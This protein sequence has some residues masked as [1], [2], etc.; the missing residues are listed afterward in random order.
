MGV[1]AASWRHAVERDAAWSLGAADGLRVLRAGV[2]EG[3]LAGGCLVDLGGGAGDAVCD[4]AGDADAPRVLFLED[5]GTKPYQWD[6]M[7]LHLRYAG[8]LEHVSGIV[9]GDMRQCVAPE[10]ERAAGGGDSACAAGFCGADCDWAAVGACG[11][12]ER[13]GAAGSAGAAGFE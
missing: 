1:D 10:E 3:T 9:F 4:A 7:L 11:C 8:M 5:I 6:R 2:A 12:A 13:Y